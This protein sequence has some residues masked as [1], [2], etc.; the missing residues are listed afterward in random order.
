MIQDHPNIMRLYEFFDE[1]TR[2]LVV[3][4][5]CKGGE[6]WEEMQNRARWTEKEAAII[7]KQVLTALNH[8]HSNNIVH[9]DVKPENIMLEDLKKLDQIKLIDFGVATRIKNLNEKLTEQVGSPYYIAPEV[10]K[11]SYNYK[12]D[13][14]STGVITYM[15][16]SGMVPFQ[17]TNSNEILTKVEAGNYEMKQGWQSVSE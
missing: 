13:L 8:C 4:E 7:T 2:Y 3:A 15:L 1:E 6:L 11:G 9:R 14:W 16:L 10:I 12:C 17:G 5:L